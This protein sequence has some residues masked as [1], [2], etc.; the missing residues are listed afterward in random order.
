MTAFLEN[1]R[2]G[3]RPAP[4][5]VAHDVRA[6][7]RTDILIGVDAENPADGS[8][9]EQRLDLAVDRRITQHE[10]SR[11]VAAA[12]AV[13]LENPH[14]V[15]DGGGERL[16]G[17]H[18]LARLEGG[19]DLFG[20]ETVGRK[21]HRPLHPGHGERLLTAAAD[22][23]FG[24]SQ[25]SAAG[26]G[27]GAVGIVQRGQFDPGAPGEQ[28]AGDHAAPARGEQGDSDSGLIHG[29]VFPCN[30]LCAVVR[31]TRAAS[32]SPASRGSR[33]SSQ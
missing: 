12:P 23:R 2:S 33:T 27:D 18:V 28:E 19:D 31:V 7:L 6:M 25:L 21:D 22:A 10:T 26:F 5:P 17:E 13:G 11:E 3:E 30:R 8:G 9:V 4:P 1:V 29:C 14:A 32:V 15:A 16:L 20:V 24:K